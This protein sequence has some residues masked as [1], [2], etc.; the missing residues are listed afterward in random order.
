VTC[1]KSADS[2]AH[3]MIV[4]LLPYLKWTLEA[5]HGKIAM[6][7][8][9]KWIKLATHLRFTEAF[10][11]PKEECVQNKSSKMLTAVLSDADGLYWEAEVQ[12]APPKWKNIKVDDESVLDSISTVKMAISSVRTHTNQTTAQTTT[13]EAKVTKTPTDA[14]TVDS[15][16]STIMQLTK[17]V[18]ILQLAHNEINS[19]LDKLTK[20]IMAQAVKPTTPTQSKQKAV[21]GLQGSPSQET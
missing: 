17:Q 10:W 8:V 21:R 15:Q 7:Q 4:A 1:L 13:M 16:M 6:A 3:A 12:D 9:P 19:K 2:L 5:K 11:D 14:K 20:F 18:S